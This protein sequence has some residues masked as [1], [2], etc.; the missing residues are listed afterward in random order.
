MVTPM[1]T[2]EEWNFSIIRAFILL[3]PELF[4]QIIAVSLFL[5][6]LCPTGT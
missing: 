3:K 2:L 4:A 6:F 5:L 1:K